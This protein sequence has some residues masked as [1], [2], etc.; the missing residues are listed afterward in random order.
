MICCGRKKSWRRGERVLVARKGNKEKEKKWR[1][2]KKTKQKKV[3][4]EEEEEEDEPLFSSW[5]NSLLATHN[6][7]S[8]STGEIRRKKRPDEISFSLSFSKLTTKKSY[9]IFLLRVPP[10]YTILLLIIFLFLTAHRVRIRWTGGSLRWTTVWNV[11]MRNCHPSKQTPQVMGSFLFSQ[12]KMVC[13]LF[14][15]GNGFLHSCEWHSHNLTHTQNECLLVTFSGGSFSRFFL[16]TFSI[17]VF[18]SFS[19]SPWALDDYFSLHDTE[20][21]CT[22]FL[23]LLISFCLFFYCYN[24]L[25]RKKEKI[26]NLTSYSYRLTGFFIFCCLPSRLSLWLFTSWNIMEIK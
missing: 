9:L 1:K 6:H 4:E 22:I 13:V 7:V 14:F 26:L 21:T 3:A 23:S 8:Q 20:E 24:A 11:G 2:K 18:R 5:R 10:I 19:F 25:K 16:D 15:F 12:E 17:L